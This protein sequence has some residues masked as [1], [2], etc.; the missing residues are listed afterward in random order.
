[1]SLSTFLAH[2]NVQRILALFLLIT[3]AAYF[4]VKGFYAS[5]KSIAAY[6]VLGL[7]FIMDFFITCGTTGLLFLINSIFYNHPAFENGFWKQYKRTFLGK[8]LVLILL[9]ACLFASFRIFPDWEVFFV[10]LFRTYG[11]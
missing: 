10:D 8:Y 11:K 5:E 9:S 4:V 7:A 3:I 2:R 6:Q 1:M